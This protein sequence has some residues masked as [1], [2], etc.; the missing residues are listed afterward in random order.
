MK[1][2]KVERASIVLMMLAGTASWGQTASMGTG[3]PTMATA[4]PAGAAEK[5]GLDY[6]LAHQDANGAWLPQVGPGVTALQW[7]GGLVQSG[8]WI[9]DPAVKKGLDFIASTKQ[10]DGGY[11]KDSNPNYNSAIVL[12]MFWNDSGG[13]GNARSRKEARKCPMR[14]KCGGIAAIFKVTAAG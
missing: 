7:C 11:Y 5:K 1:M 12:S 13:V 10:K 4:K 14:R 3:L 2:V 8:K 9:D 6:L